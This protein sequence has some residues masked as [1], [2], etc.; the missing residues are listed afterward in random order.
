MLKSQKSIHAHT[1]A[2]THTHTRGSDFQGS[3]LTADK[4]TEQI[5]ILRCMPACSYKCIHTH[6][7]FVYA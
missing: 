2:R 3:Q 1:H 6:C 4:H 5:D 7:L